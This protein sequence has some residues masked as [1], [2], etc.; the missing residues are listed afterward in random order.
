VSSSPP[1]PPLPQGE[2]AG[3][4]AP[5]LTTPGR[6]AFITLLAALPWILVLS[7]FL[8]VIPRYE[9]MFREH[10]LK[11]TPFTALLIDI[12]AWARSHVLFALALTIVLVFATVG[13]VVAVQAG[14]VSRRIRSLVLLLAFGVP[15]GLFILSW[16]GV[17]GTHRTLVEGL[18]K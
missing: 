1:N 13:A 3:G 9:R 11:L 4:P 6:Q 16:V 5:A 15:C 10:G 18:N 17:M 12:S 8:L 14:L 7:Q 2:G